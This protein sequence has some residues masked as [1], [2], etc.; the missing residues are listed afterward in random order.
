MPRGHAHIRFRALTL[1]AA[2]AVCLFPRIATADPLAVIA[3]MKGRVEVVAGKAAPQ[4]ATF[5]RGLERGDRVVVG[6]G[7]S[8]TVFFH[9]GNVI[10]LSEK[11]SV[12]IGGKVADSK[13]GAPGLPGDVYA[14]VSRY[15]TGG[16]RETGLVAY[17]ATRSSDESLAMLLA[18]RQATIGPGRPA[19]SWRPVPGAERYVVTVTRDGNEVWTQEST[20]GAEMPWPAEPA[21]TAGEYAWE[22]RAF[23]PQGELRREDSVFRVLDDTEAGAVHANLERIGAS[24]G[25]ADHPASHFLAGSYL[26][27]RGLYHAAAHHFEALARLSPESPAPH[28]ALGN[29]YRAIGLM[30]LAAAEYQKALALT[31]EP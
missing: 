7:A 3:A 18:P 20:S 27:G 6:P 25:G 16:S 8:A 23:G 21:P 12:T 15:V 29:V 28:E 1:A 31:R 13:K 17:S 10:E 5:G 9:D 11:S 19:F 22:V 2:T 24:A 30:D 4:R 26:F 14:S